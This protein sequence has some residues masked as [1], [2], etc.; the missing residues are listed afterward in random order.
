MVVS[1]VQY[2]CLWK[3]GSTGRIT[4]SHSV[5]CLHCLRVPEPRGE[6][7]SSPEPPVLNHKSTMST[8]WN[9]ERDS[10]LAKPAF[11]MLSL[12]EHLD[13]RMFQRTVGVS[14]RCPKQIE[15]QLRLQ[16]PINFRSVPVQLA[17]FSFQAEQWLFCTLSFFLYNM[18]YWNKSLTI[19][20]IQSSMFASIFS[21]LVSEF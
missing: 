1:R 6:Q 4:A 10:G 20:K 13:S 19:I 8:H 14:F 11:Q 17:M 15:S 21:C 18:S 7:A 12:H 5:S 16:I 9:W 3:W 2:L